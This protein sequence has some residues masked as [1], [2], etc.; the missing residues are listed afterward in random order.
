MSPVKLQGDK[1]TKFSVPNGQGIHINEG[2]V[3]FWSDKIDNFAMIAASQVDVVVTNYFLQQKLHQQSITDGL[4]KL[5]N[6]RY[7]MDTFAKE[8]TDAKQLGFILFDI[9]YFKTYNDEFGHPAGD[10]L[11]KQLSVLAM[12]ITRKT[13]IVGRL[14]GE[15]FG[16][17]TKE[18]SKDGLLIV[19]EKIRTSIESTLVPPTSKKPVTVSIGGSLY[20]FDGE[21]LDA[22]YLCADQRLYQAKEQGRNRTII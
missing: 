16:V 1:M 2:S 14:G 11:L 8:L 15:E 9:D 5:H 19:A 17:L 6:R 3:I 7:F 20:P 10:E 21:D 12:Q 4:T 13:D 18:V 22:L